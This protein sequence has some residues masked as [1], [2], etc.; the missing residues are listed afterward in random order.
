MH[1]LCRVIRYTCNIYIYIYVCIQKVYLIGCASFILSL[2]FKQLN[3]VIILYPNLLTIS[4]LR[5]ATGKTVISQPT[6]G[7]P[8]CRSM[9]TTPARLSCLKHSATRKRVQEKPRKQHNKPMQRKNTFSGSFFNK[10]RTYSPI[11]SGYSFYSY[12][13]STS[14]SK[15]RRT[16][17][18]LV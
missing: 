8:K 2:F 14:R 6:K 4:W 7:Q 11:S 12:R 13:T 1:R 17:R 15:T 16:I 10:H 9:G 3:S 18:F 5:P